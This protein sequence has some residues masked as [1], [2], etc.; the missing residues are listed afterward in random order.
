MG[1]VKEEDIVCGG[2]KISDRLRETGCNPSLHMRGCAW[3]YAG[4]LCYMVVM[5]VGCRNFANETVGRCVL[6][7]FRPME[8]DPLL[9]CG[10]PSGLG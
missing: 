7:I 9:I 10:G 5:E 4:R 6:R 2:K 8:G 1:D 3:G